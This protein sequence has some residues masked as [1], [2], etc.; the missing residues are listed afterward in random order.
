MSSL[1]I[2]ILALA[3]FAAVQAVGAYKCTGCRPDISVM[4]AILAIAAALA[5]LEISD[6]NG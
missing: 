3:I 4:L 1:S 2:V 5:L 6:M